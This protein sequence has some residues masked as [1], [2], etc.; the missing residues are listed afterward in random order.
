MRRQRM[1]LVLFACLLG[2]SFFP[3]DSAAHT[4]S[5][6]FSR[7]RFTNSIL[8]M[9]FTVNAREATRIGGASELPALDRQLADYLAS[10][11]EVIGV[12]SDCRQS[13]APAP[14][15]SRAGFLRVEATWMCARLPESLGLH[16][17]FDLA[18]EHV[19]FASL[20]FQ[21]DLRQ[22]VL[23][24]ENP[25]W[26]LTEPVSAAS[27]SK[28]P[29]SG[30]LDY[31]ALGF[32]HILGGADHLAFLAGLLL[33]CRRP[34]DVIWAIT[35]F[36]LG[37][38]ISLSLAVLGVVQAN[39]PAIE[40]TIGLTIVLVALERT[41]GFYRSV[42]L[43]ALAAAALVLLI[44][45][46]SANHAAGI[47]ASMGGNIGAA[48][49]VGLALFSFCYIMFSHSLGGA[50]RFRVLVT[51][52]FGL[53]HGFGFAGAFQAAGMESGILVPLAGFNLGIEIGQLVLWSCMITVAVLVRRISRDLAAHAADLATAAIC[54]MGVFWFVQRSFAA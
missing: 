20:E 17:F 2:G 1:H 28:E 44:I 14:T 47:G 42:L 36:T 3:P 48:A 4:P 35:G 34:R 50:G 51:A 13:H 33:L 37:H 15:A 32:R 25:V 9:E 43:A 29:G 24:A 38:S 53:I 26:V 40:A 12:E 41:A 18:P 10:R 52:L 16:A 54:G 5:E 8:S 45:P 39:V 11:V 22:M 7:W 23:T 30:F 31:L 6:S 21:G 49:L 19:H 46:I 27:A